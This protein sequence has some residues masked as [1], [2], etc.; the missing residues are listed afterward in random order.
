MILTLLEKVASALILRFKPKVVCITGSVG[1]TSTKEAIASALITSYT[2]RKT[3]RNY[4]NDYGVPIAV[5]GGF[6]SEEGFFALATILIYGLWQ[7][8]F[9]SKFPQVLVIEVGAGKIGEIE[10]IAKWLKPDMVVVT[11]LPDVP[12]HLGVFGSKEMIIREKKFLVS[13]MDK[14]GIL[15]IDKNES[16]AKYF[17]ENFHGKTLFYDG[18]KFIRESNYT[19]VY[20]DQD[21]FNH[22]VGFKFEASLNNIESKGSK[23]ILTFSGF[24]GIQ[25][26]KAINAAILVAIELNCDADNILKGI[27]K[28]KPE[29]GRLRIIPE[30]DGKVTVLDDTFNASPRAI[31]NSV[32]TLLS[33]EIKNGQRRIAVL[34]DMINF[35]KD[36]ERIHKQTAARELS[37]VDILITVGN[38]SNVW[39]EFNKNSHH[40]NRHFKN[41]TNAARYIEKFQKDGDIILF[42]GGHLVRLEKAVAFLTGCSSECLVRQEKY[43]KTHE[44]D[45]NPISADHE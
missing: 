39:Q 19:I 13:A 20:K 18:D 28:Y 11:N 33:L 22:P 7:L 26:M 16:N 30:P 15:I 10:R 41:S 12:S 5:I 23:K 27:Q 38:V 43:Y 37:R 6:E 17:Y 3:S 14:E 8:Y 32:K 4:N 25:N 21:N 35:G 9:Q 45:L 42:K 24:L 29:C 36:V 1:K 34:G 31:E 40:L 44:L 2:V